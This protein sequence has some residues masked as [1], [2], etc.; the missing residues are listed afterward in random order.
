MAEWNS[1]RL[2]ALLATNIDALVLAAVRDGKSAEL[3]AF[4]N[5]LARQAKLAPAQPEVA[6]PWAD[7]H[8]AMG[9]EEKK[10]GLEHLNIKVVTQDG[11]EIHFKCKQ[12]TPLQKLMHAFC[13]R[14]GWSMGTVRFLFDGNLIRERDTP[15][16]LD[17]EDNDVIDVMREQQGGCIASPV[18]ALFG[19][20]AHAVGLRYLECA[21]ELTHATPQDARAIVLQLGGSL[22]AEPKVVV[23]P[24]LDA[25]ACAAL[26]TYLDERAAAHETGAAPD[27]RL[28]LGEAELEVL[29]GQQAC[30]AV[31]AAFGAPF[32][33]IRLR[34]AEASAPL[35]QCVAFHTD[36]SKRT[37]QVA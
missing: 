12:T 25:S 2:S 34:R 24:V 35:P 36:F 37:M 3:E 22:D 4:S 13:N 21:G 31:V 27:L 10:E 33:A 20:H 9:D 6:N 5:N 26:T 7:D 30:A 18:P 1:R 32:D 11:N 16:Q 8:L 14:Q 29:I 28:T 17:M 15:A 23:E 19:A